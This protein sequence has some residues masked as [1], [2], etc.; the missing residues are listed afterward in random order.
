ME[1]EKTVS[2][3]LDDL[4][5]ISNDGV[6]YWMARDIQLPLGYLKWDKFEGVIKKGQMSCEST[7]ADPNNHILQTGKMVK[8][9]S[10]ALREKRDYFVSRYGA[11]LIAM[12]GNPKLREIATAQSYFAIQARKQEITEQARDIEKRI[13]L[14]NRV[15]IANKHLGDAAKESGVQNYALFHDAGYR[16]LYNL[17][18]GEIKERKGLSPKEQLLDR[19]GRAELAANEFRITQTEEALKRDDISG[20]TNARETHRRVGEKVRDTIDKIGGTMPEDLPAEPSIKKLAV[21][22]HKKKKTIEGK[23]NGDNEKV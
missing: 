21:N 20:D 7:G 4:K 1:I 10:G 19:A 3:S 23:T 18:L 8:I 14:R 5:K 22:K 2:Q 6:E 16:G 11:Y 13:E 17:S 12:N 9:G 15:K